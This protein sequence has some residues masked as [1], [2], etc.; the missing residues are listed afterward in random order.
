ML[1]DLDALGVADN[2]LLLHNSDRALAEFTVIKVG[3]AVEVVKVAQVVES[4]IVVEGVEWA[5]GNWKRKV[6]GQFL[7]SARL[8]KRMTYLAQ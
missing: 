5:T 7:R 8:M 2:F 4:T 3:G 6:R 1:D